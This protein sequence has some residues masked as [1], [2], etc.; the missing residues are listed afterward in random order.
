MR[1][2]GGGGLPGKGVTFGFDVARTSMISSFTMVG[3]EE[4][5]LFFYVYSTVTPLHDAN[6]YNDGCM[7]GTDLSFYSMVCLFQDIYS[8]R[9]SEGKGEDEGGEFRTFVCIS[10]LCR[11]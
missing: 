10:L 2:H 6:D 3:E 9:V 4:V 1:K 7:H 11:I 5:D 8:E